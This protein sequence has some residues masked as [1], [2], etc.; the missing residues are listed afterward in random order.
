MPAVWVALSGL[1]SFGAHRI[2]GRL[3]QSDAQTQSGPDRPAEVW[4]EILAALLVGVLLLAMNAR[5]LIPP[6]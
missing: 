2:S 4:L 3:H 1:V 5:R 6:A